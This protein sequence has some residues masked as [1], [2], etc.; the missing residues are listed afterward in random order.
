MQY[1]S[2]CRMN[3]KPCRRGRPFQGRVP[4]NRKKIN[5]LGFDKI[6]VASEGTELFSR[7]KNCSTQLT[8]SSPVVICGV[9]IINNKLFL[10]IGQRRRDDGSSDGREKDQIE[11][12][13][14]RNYTEVDKLNITGLSSSEEND[15][16]S[17]NYN[18]CF[19]ISD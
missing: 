13:E 6:Q 17:C 8:S 12:Y 4:P 19:Y 5:I 14:R 1:A 16:T 10:L 7:V 9:T 11:V 3:C 15:I 2:Q 18:N